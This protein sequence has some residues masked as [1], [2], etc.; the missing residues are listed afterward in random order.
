MIGLLTRAS[1]RLLPR[2]H[3]EAVLGDLAE[4]RVVPGSADE[5]FA[6]APIALRLH[7]DAWRDERARLGAVAAG[8][9]ASGLLWAVPAAGWP[10]PSA[11]LDLY[12]DPVSRA[13]I[14][15]WS[16][17]HL[18]GP[19]AAGLLIG[20]VGWIPARASFMR[21]HVALALVVPVALAGPDGLSALPPVLL[22]MATGL[23]DRARGN[24]P[25]VMG[26]AP[27]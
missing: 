18:T 23:A 10:D 9:L 22:L 4:E 6:I 1:A 7:A 14:A 8:A 24:D 19:T 2:R 21:W 15:F 25:K 26:A 17:T 13:A 11:A 12:G 27:R 20:H 3:R 5:L 16:A